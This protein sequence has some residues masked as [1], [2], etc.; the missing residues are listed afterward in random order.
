MTGRASLFF[1]PLKVWGSNKN[2]A[3]YQIEHTPKLLT[4]LWLIFSEK[5]RV[6]TIFLKS[7]EKSRF[8][9]WKSQCFTI[10][11]LPWMTKRKRTG[12]SDYVRTLVSK[13]DC[14][15]WKS[16]EKASRTPRWIRLKKLVRVVLVSKRDCEKV[17]KTPR[18]IRLR[19]L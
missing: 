7:F 12:E 19:N 9:C 4:T 17:A 10:F 15:L 11:Y 13:R 14:E 2:L 6:E 16:I 8:F 1:L 3:Y 18:W 5:L